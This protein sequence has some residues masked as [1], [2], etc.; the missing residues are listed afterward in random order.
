MTGNW[1]L[2][3]FLLLLCSVAKKEEL[4]NLRHAR[5]RNVIE[6]MFGCVKRKW[7]VLKHGCELPLED[8]IKIV[9]TLFGLYNFIT[10]IETQEDSDSEDYT[11]TSHTYAND[12]T[13]SDDSDESDGSNELESVDTSRAQHTASL[14]GTMESDTGTIGF[15]GTKAAGTRLRED[16]ANTMWEDRR[17]A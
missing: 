16:M 11:G 9:P 4:Y 6:R 15:Q 12:N 2:I 8:Q 14:G 7:K 1:L 10:M 3:A 5:L 17:N 13:V